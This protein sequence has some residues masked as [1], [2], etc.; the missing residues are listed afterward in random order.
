[1]A[2]PP[3]SM[4]PKPISTA[5]I[6]AFR[7][8]VGPSNPWNFSSLFIAAAR[9]DPITTPGTSPISN[10]S[11]EDRSRKNISVLADGPVKVRLSICTGSKALC[12]SA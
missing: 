4:P 2:Q 1:M 5:P 11:T 6:I 9:K 3:A 10:S 8:G 12:A 7:I